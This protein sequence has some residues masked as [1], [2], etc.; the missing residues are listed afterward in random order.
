MEARGDQSD[1]SPRIPVQFGLPGIAASVYSHAE[2]PPLMHGNNWTGQNVS[3]WWCSE[4]FHGWR[5][6]WTG[7][8]LVSRLGMVYQA[9]VWFTMTLPFFPLDCELWLGR[10][11]TADD[12]HKAIAAGEWSRLR[13]AVFDCPG[14][15][16]EEAIATI[17]ATRFPSNAIAAEFWQ[18]KSAEG[19]RLAMLQVVAN[20][21]EGVMLR[22]PRSMY[23]NIRTSDLLKLT[24]AQINRGPL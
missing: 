4:K 6:Y 13:L 20:G 19:A 7:E 11:F 22:K 18:V 14:M 8:R 24:P 5:A 15:K 2:I 12:V 1:S 16:I 17:R 3:D 21:G 23:R 9:P 10:G